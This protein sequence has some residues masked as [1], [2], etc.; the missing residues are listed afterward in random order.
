MKRSL[1]E[2]LIRIVILFIGVQERHIE[3]AC[4]NS[5]R[6]G[7]HNLMHSHIF[8][9]LFLNYQY[10]A[11]LNTMQFESAFRSV[12]FAEY[13]N[14]FI[15]SADIFTYWEHRRGGLIFLWIYQCIAIIPRYCKQRGIDIVLRIE[16]QC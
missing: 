1:K 7:I 8:N 4:R 12:H 15:K 9:W 10:R 14:D 13:H 11:I 5:G 3:R 6:Y 16:S 2:I